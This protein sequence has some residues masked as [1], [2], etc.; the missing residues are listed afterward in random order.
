M[1]RLVL[2]TLHFLY[3]SWLTEMM[4]SGTYPHSYLEP[5]TVIS[6]SKR[7]YEDVIKFKDG[8][9]GIVFWVLQVLRWVQCY[10]KDS[11]KRKTEGSVSQK[12]RCDSGSR[13]E[14]E[15]TG[16][17]ISLILKT[18]E[19]GVTEPKTATASGTWKKKGMNPPLWLR[20]NQPCI[21]LIS[22]D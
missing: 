15:M 22:P 6:H 14:A 11:H 16:R 7:D 12:R 4:V 13:R 2:R 21:H 17:Y 8:E 18:E 1:P 19:E 5:V 9:M 3:I 20:R 10:R